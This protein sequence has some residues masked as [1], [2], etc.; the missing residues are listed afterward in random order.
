MSTEYFSDDSRQTTTKGITE[1]RG[2]SISKKKKKKLNL[3]KK[4]HVDKKILQAM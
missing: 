1:M 2:R 3:E 4:F